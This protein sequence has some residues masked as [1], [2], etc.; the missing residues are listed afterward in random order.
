[1]GGSPFPASFCARCARRQVHA[2][3]RERAAVGVRCAAVTIS[4]RS[5]IVCLLTG[6]NLLNYLDRY[7]ITAVSP[8]IQD[9]LHLSDFQTGAILSAFMLGYFITSPAFGALGDKHARK[10]LISIGVALWSIATA[11]SGLARGFISMS[12]ARV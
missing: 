11:V 3:R 10:G 4:S 1:M 6:L 7:I 8:R 9:E 12:M 5:G 2:G